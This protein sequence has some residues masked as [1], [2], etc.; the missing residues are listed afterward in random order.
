MDGCDHD[1]GLTDER[2][3]F[4]GDLRLLMAREHIN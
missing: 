3:I 2:K 1:S 4:L